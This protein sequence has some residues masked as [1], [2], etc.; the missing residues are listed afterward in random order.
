MLDDG[1]QHDTLSGGSAV[2][3]LLPQVLPPQLPKRQPVII[4]RKLVVPGLIE[5]I[6]VVL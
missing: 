1:L 5:V 6:N 2:V 4:H 3:A